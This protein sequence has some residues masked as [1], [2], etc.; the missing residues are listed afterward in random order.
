[1]SLSSLSL[2]SASSFASPD[3]FFFLTP[4]LALPGGLVAPNGGG[5]SGYVGGFGSVDRI[6][7]SEGRVVSLLGEIRGVGSVDEAAGSDGKISAGAARD[8]APSDT[9]AGFA[10]KGSSSAGV[11]GKAWERIKSDSFGCI[12]VDL[13][14]EATFLADANPFKVARSG[15]PLLKLIPQVEQTVPLF[16][17]PRSGALIFE[18]FFRLALKVPSRKPPQTLHHPGIAVEGTE[19][20]KRTR[21]RWRAARDGEIGWRSWG[22]ARRWSTVV[23]SVSLEGAW[24]RD[25]C[26][27]EE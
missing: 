15:L 22:S 12:L 26:S 21:A 9:M 14:V 5:G 2:F 3:F 19:R 7:E 20:S 18:P 13:L 27:M 8:D 16:S 25:I 11:A 4:A 23:G 17:T 24:K 6:Y 1:L 10:M